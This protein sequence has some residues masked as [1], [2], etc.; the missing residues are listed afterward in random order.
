MDPKLKSLRLNK[1]YL[2]VIDGKKSIASEADAKNFLQAIIDQKD[3]STCTEKLV[4][5]S[6]GLQAVKK[7]LRINTSSKFINETTALFLDYISHED[8]RQLCGGQIQQNILEAIIEPPSFWN[9]FESCFNE[10]TLSPAGL[11]SYASLILELLLSPAP[12]PQLDVRKTA[13]RAISERGDLIDSSNTNIRNVVKSIQEALRA[14]I[15]GAIVSGGAKPGGRH[16]NDFEDFREIAIFPTTDEFK[17]KEKPFYLSA[18]EVFITDPS[19]RVARHLDNQFRLL[20]EDM[21]GELR[22]DLQVASGRKRVKQKSLRIKGLSFYGV[23]CGEQRKRKPPTIALFC[24][25]GLP[26]L[27]NST[28]DERK[29]H[30][31]DNRDIVKHQSFGCLL[32]AN[33]VVAFA[34]VER[35]ED[36]LAE[37]PPVLL[38]RIF[39]QKAIKKMLITLKLHTPDQLEFL[40]IDTAFFAYEPVLRGLQ[41]MAI[42]PLSDELLNLTESRDV[43]MSSIVSDALVSK[44]RTKEGCNLRGALKL[45]KDVVLD[46]SQTQSLVA[47]LSQRVSLIQGPPGM[48][49]L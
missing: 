9:A 3:R 27:P 1:L 12:F 21:L 23:N 33:E 43:S 17:S 20:R 36:L 14:R 22:T 46:Q 48:I 31:K 40:T 34:T 25:Q 13:E 39:G 44:V 28:K 42:L 16:D 30:Y 26:K 24:H 32:C 2:M 38:L 41:S 37:E 49:S 15:T 18:D 19:N 7:S 45:P 29:K 35:N 4:V 11:H 47:G 6:Q 8:I 10:K 5:S